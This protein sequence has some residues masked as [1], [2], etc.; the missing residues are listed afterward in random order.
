MALLAAPAS[1]QYTITTVAGGGQPQDGVGDGGPATSAELIPWGLAVDSAGNLYIADSLGSRIRKVSTNGTITTVAGGGPCCALGDGNPAT[2]ATLSSPAGVAVDASGNLYIADSASARVRKVSTNG[3]ISTFAGGGSQTLAPGGSASAS[4]L[5]FQAPTGIAVDTGGNIYVTDGLIE[6]TVYE[7]SPAGMA[8][9]VAGG[10]DNFLALGNGDGGPATKATLSEPAGIAVDSAGNLY[11]ADALENRV[12]KVSTNGIITTFAGSNSGSFSGDGGPASQAGL[13]LS[14]TVPTSIS[15]VAVDA[16]GNVYISDTD[17]ERIRMVNPGGIISTIAGTGVEGS[18]GDGG[19]ATQATLDTPGGLAVGKGGVLYIADF[20]QDNYQN[21]RV[22]ALIPST[23]P[24]PSISAGGIVSASAFGGFSA[25][26]PGSWVE[27]YGTN[28]AT[29]SRSWTGNDF[30]GDTAPTSLDGT[31]VTIGG[32]PTYVDYISPTQVNVQVPSNVG[33]GSQQVIVAS[34]GA[35]S[36]AAPIVVNTTEPGLLAPASFKIAGTQYVAA[37]YSDGVTF[38]LPP[39]AI[40][41]VP[42][43]RAQPGD[44]ITLYGVGF[45][46]VTPNIPAGQIAGTSNSLAAPFGVFFGQA[47]ATVLYDG[48]APNEVGLYQFNVTVPAIASSDFVPLTFTLNGVSGTQTLYISVQNGSAP[49]ETQVQS[50]TLSSTS[51]S[52]GSSVTGTVT[53]SQAAGAGGAIVALS[54]NSSSASVPAT[55]TVPAGATS[56]TFTI[57]T[58]SVS[59]SS[60]ATITATYSGSSAQTT[61]TVAS[62]GSTLPHFTTLTL[63]GT[64]QPVGYP[65]ASILVTILPNAGNTTYTAELQFPSILTFLNG[66]ASNGNRNFVFNVIQSVDGVPPAFTAGAT[67]LQVTSASLSFTLSPGTSSIGSGSVSGTLT[68]TG[69]PAGSGGSPSTI[70]GDFL[71]TYFSN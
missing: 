19:T 7:I 39:G 32:Q 4:S 17:D 55:V 44:N 71:G 26:A 10:P 15:G 42:S 20:V 69:T 45:G 1:A 6:G 43:R 62:G 67:T 47:E 8:T 63:T 50:V 25:I 61:L 11:I 48:L 33:T 18:S 65:A 21:A 29:D 14:Q 57:S 23:P 5:R 68:V 40:A 64:Y 54:S 3:I 16:S 37:V 66:T 60:T 38:V 22:R 27:I 31:S 30:K 12:R 28:L 52:G 46:S 41:G 35:Q 34:S 53:L 13:S 49:P 70:T 51:V 36:A 24:G 9:I 59:S 56:A 2:S 58:A